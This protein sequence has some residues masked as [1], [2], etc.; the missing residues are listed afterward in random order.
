MFYELRSSLQE[1]VEGR[2]LSPK[3]GA[4][5]LISFDWIVCRGDPAGRKCSTAHVRNNMCTT[6]VFL[7]VLS[8]AS[9]LAIPFRWQILRE[10]TESAV[11]HW[12]GSGALVLSHHLS[13]ASPPM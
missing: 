12:P 9:V 7:P 11:P 3:L 8:Q 4:P 6:G 5:R 2:L 1:R 13:V 10:T